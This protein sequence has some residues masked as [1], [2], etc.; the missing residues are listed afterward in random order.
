MRR[1]TRGAIRNDKGTRKLHDVP[2]QRAMLASYRIRLDH[3]APVGA[4]FE[5]C[6]AKAYLTQGFLRSTS[7][8]VPALA[9]KIRDLEWG[10][11]ARHA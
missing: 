8:S 5:F 6:R 2:L 11:A 1:S 9:Q 4:V 7:A 10:K 3:P